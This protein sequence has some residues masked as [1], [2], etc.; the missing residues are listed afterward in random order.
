MVLKTTKD[1]VDNQPQAV[2]SDFL[3]VCGCCCEHVKQLHQHRRQ[4]VDEDVGFCGVKALK[5]DKNDKYKQKLKYLLYKFELNHPDVSGNTITFKSLIS[6]EELPSEVISWQCWKN[7]WRYKSCRRH[8]QS[9]NKP[10]CVPRPG[11][12]R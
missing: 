5:E 3:G 7:F 1:C 12:S 9:E 2:D 10:L 11:S 6:S 8:I 4:K